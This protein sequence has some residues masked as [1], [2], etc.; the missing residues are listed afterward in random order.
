MSTPTSPP[1]PS[2]AALRRAGWPDPAMRVSDTD[3]SEIADRLAK[4]YS[5]GRLDKAEF[6]QRL[7]QALQ[8]KTRADLIGLLADLPDGDGG[9]P[10]RD[11]HRPRSQRRQ[12]GPILKVPVERE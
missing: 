8:A 12:H 10:P 5:D 4:H 6:E 1:R 2:A 11:P 3:R 7:D 9:P